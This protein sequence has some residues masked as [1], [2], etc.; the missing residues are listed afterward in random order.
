RQNPPQPQP[1]PHWKFFPEKL[2][3]RLL[4]SAGSCPPLGF[5]ADGAMPLQSILWQFDALHGDLQLYQFNRKVCELKLYC[6]T[7][8]VMRTY[9][10]W[11]SAFIS[12]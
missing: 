12:L 10:L 2:S 1:V 4:C 5:P 8:V 6:V 9:L 7:Q 3:P 11:Q